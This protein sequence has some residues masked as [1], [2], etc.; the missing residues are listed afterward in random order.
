MSK[1]TPGPWCVEPASNG[2]FDIYRET[3]EGE[4]PP[5]ACDCNEA[6]ARLIAAAPALLEAVQASELLLRQ[7]GMKGN[8]LHQQ[9]CAAIASATGGEQ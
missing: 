8:G 4:A 1:H 5:V 3:N 6:D 2:C 9:L 7:I